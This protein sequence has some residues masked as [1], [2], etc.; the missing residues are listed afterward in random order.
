MS[1][2]HPAIEE[3]EAAE[4]KAAWP[5]RT[6]HCNEQRKERRGQRRATLSKA[7]LHAQIRCRCGPARRQC[8]KTT[9]WEPAIRRQHKQAHVASDAKVIYSTSSG[10]HEEVCQTSIMAEPAAWC[11]RQHIEVPGV[12]AAA[13]RREALC[14]TL[15]P[16]SVF[17]RFHD[18][19]LTPKSVTDE[20]APPLPQVTP[21]LP[22]P[23]VPPPMVES[24]ARR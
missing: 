7:P 20:C 2:G 15:Y 24:K 14:A 1:P 5:K 23:E 6:P 11:R 4:H 12:P 19:S 3:N 10:E 22:S 16:L 17:E 8:G 21:E 13:S 9:I 18:A